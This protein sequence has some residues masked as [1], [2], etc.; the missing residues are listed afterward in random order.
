MPQAEEAPPATNGAAKKGIMD[1][2]T[3]PTGQLIFNLIRAAGEE[4]GV[5]N[6]IQQVK[7][8]K[9]QQKM[10]ADPPQL[11]AMM[12][13]LATMERYRYIIANEINERFKGID[14]Q[15]ITEL[16]IVITEPPAE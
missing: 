12:N 1:V 4:I 6:A 15:R 16:G 2:R 8:M 5:G 9:E 10:V 3:V 11:E 7:A 13:H 14:Q